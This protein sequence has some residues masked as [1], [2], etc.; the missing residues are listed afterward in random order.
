MTTRAVSLSGTYTP[1]GGAVIRALH[2]TPRG[3]IAQEGGG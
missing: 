2:N 1:C 3:L